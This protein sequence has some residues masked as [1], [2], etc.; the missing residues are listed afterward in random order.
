MPESAV[1]V[2]TAVRA[3][4]L[5]ARAVTEAALARIAEQNP[6]VNAFT[7]VTT[8][9]AL[10]EAARVDATARAGGDPGPLAGVPFAV[11][12]LFD[13]AGVTTLAGSKIRADCAPAREDATAVR[14]LCE[15]GAVL[16]GALNMEEFAYG[17]LTDNAHYGRTLNPHDLSRTAGGSSGGSSAAVAAGLVP[18]ALGTDTNGSVRVPAAFC[19][20]VG[21]KPTYG[22]LDRSGM[23]FLAPSLDHVGPFA[24]TVDDIASVLGALTGTAD[25]AGGD[26]ASALRVGIAGG[27]FAEVMSARVRRAVEH[28]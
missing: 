15:A 3:G 21:L 18:V 9:R 28:A 2:A 17:F 24:R 1:A 26:R 27:Y 13:I 11:K 10:A 14:R 22:R 23:V 20:V 25:T 4:A 8:D 16:V 7:I 12:N 5:S 6:A 19:G